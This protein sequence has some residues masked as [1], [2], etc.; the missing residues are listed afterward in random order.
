MNTLVHGAWWVR[1][2]LCLIEEELWFAGQRTADL[3]YQFGTPSFF[4]NSKRVFENIRRIRSALQASGIKDRSRIHF[5]M[6]ANRF[7]PLLTLLQASGEV[8]IDACSPNEVECAIS[9]GFRPDQISLTANSLTPSELERLSRLPGLRINCD[10]ISAIR[11]WGELLPGSTIGIRINPA[12]GVGRT[13]NDKL[14]YSGCQT[15]KFGIYREQFSTALREAKR[16]ALK[17]NTIH[18]HTGCGYL[19]N[20]LE[21]WDAAIAEARRFIDQC[22]DIESVN[23]GGG[24]GVPH[25][26]TDEP[27]CLESWCQVLVKHFGDTRLDIEVEPGDYLVKDAG[28]LLTSVGCVERKKE[29]LFVGLNAGFNLAVEPAFYALPFQPVPAQ[30]REGHLRTTTLVGNINEALDV[31]SRDI[32]FPP[33]EEGDT[34]VILN[35]GAYSSSMAS[36]HCMRGDFKEF[37]L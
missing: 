11:R 6:K 15:T 7:V 28:I 25:S 4:Y 5:A 31:W 16:L 34:V 1:D 24:L 32:E 22:S 9:C 14:L 21:S 27:L 35:A 18:F 8:G 30:I 23:V 37:M 12:V 2:D 17:V 13:A 36:N 19:T 10:S 3:A 29:T 33:V 20:N 26:E